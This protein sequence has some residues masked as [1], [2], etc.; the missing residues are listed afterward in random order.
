MLEEKEFRK[1]IGE[2]IRKLR[3][4]KKYSTEKLAGLSD[5]DYTSLNQ[6]ENGKQN[7]KS[8]TLYKILR[9]LDIDI[10]ELITSKTKKRTNLEA[11]VIERIKMMSNDNLL[12]L[13]AFL[14]EFGIHKK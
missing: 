3:T 7:P 1:I 13:Q 4:N 8:Y 6:I 9:A 14:E 10:M 11:S 12:S 5:I 2:S